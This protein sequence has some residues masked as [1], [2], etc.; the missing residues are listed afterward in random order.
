MKRYALVDDHGT[1][2][3]YYDDRDSAEKD[4]TDL[5]NPEDLGIIEI[6]RQPTKA[7]YLR[8]VKHWMEAS[9][10]HRWQ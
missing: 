7:D 3:G 1:L 4:L 6:T 10:N 2:F 9:I 5:G 8:A